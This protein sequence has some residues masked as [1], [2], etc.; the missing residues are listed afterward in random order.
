MIWLLISNK[1]SILFRLLGLETME[2]SVG[3]EEIHIKREIIDGSEELVDVEF[4]P[5]EFAG[6]VKE[7][8]N[9]FHENNEVDYEKYPWEYETPSVQTS[10]EFDENLIL[11]TEIDIDEP[12]FAGCS[13]TEPNPKNKSHKRVSNKRKSKREFAE[14]KPKSTAP[15]PKGLHPD[16]LQFECDLCGRRYDE[17]AQMK[18]H[19]TSCRG[20]WYECYICRCSSSHWRWDRFMVHF[21][22]HTGDQ[23]FACKCCA[24]RF[25]SKRML[26]HHMKYHPNE[27]L[28]KCSFCQ[29]GFPTSAEAKQ[30]ESQCALKRQM[31]CCFCKST[32]TYKSSLQRHMSQ[33]T[34]LNKFKCKYCKKAYARKDYLDLHLQSHKQELQFHCSKCKQRF[35]QKTDLDDHKMV[36]KKKLFK[37]DLCSYSTMSDIYAED[38]KRQHIGTDEFKCWH[39]PEVFLQRSKLVLH[40]KTHNK[41]T[42]LFKCPFCQKSYKRWL[43]MEKHRQTCQNAPSSSKNI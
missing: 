6:A 2:F 11:K 35:P 14:K 5:D 27:I 36:C 3:Y 31:E 43:I 15:K 29:R 21:R 20:R 41:K 19:R 4:N 42:V 18:K 23:P 32:F 12:M 10:H 7:E 33:H 9:S 1:V 38:H 39:C 30:H 8:K 16:E 37:C 40:V 22:K 24:K 26:N 13:Q 28:S 17:I 34:G 25:S